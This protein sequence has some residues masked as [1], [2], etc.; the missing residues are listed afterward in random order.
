MF[1]TIALIFFITGIIL[2]AFGFLCRKAYY[3]MNDG[4]SEH[5][6]RL[7][8]RMKIFLLTGSIVFVIGIIFMIIHFII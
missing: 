5:Y 2:I 4:S 7:R 1:F 3:G 8:K 6:S